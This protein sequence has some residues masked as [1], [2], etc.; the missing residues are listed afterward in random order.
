MLIGDQ[1]VCLQLSLRRVLVGA[2]AR[3]PGVV[4]KVSI[5][6][7]PGVGLQ[8]SKLY[9]EATAWAD[10]TCMGMKRQSYLKP[11]ALQSDKRSHVTGV[12]IV[13]MVAP[14]KG[15]YHASVPPLTGP[16]PL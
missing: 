4:E 6:S 15:G 12:D 2:S 16:A 10:S 7:E 14:E 11:H 9:K 8:V 13:G 5:G 3:C 1:V